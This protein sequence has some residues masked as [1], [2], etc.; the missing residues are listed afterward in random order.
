MADYAHQLQ[1]DSVLMLETDANHS[2]RDGLRV[3][4]K[5]DAAFV[6]SVK[7][8]VAYTI[9]RYMRPNPNPSKAV[10]LRNPYVWRYA[11]HRVLNNGRVSMLVG[12]FLFLEEAEEYVK[13][14]MVGR[15][16]FGGTAFNTNHAG[17]ALPGNVGVVGGSADR[18][19]GAVAGTKTL[20]NGAKLM[21]QLR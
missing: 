1:R 11:V 9:Q 3:R 13:S 5:V 6:E 21:V 2:R 16:V 19:G 7:N 18:Q 12:E 14:A 17:L 20:A 10:Q 15:T 8:R 4:N